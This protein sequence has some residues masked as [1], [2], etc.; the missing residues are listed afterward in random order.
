MKRAVTVI[1]I[2]WYHIKASRSIRGGLTSLSIRERKRRDRE[3]GGET[4]ICGRPES[5]FT[6]IFIWLLLQFIDTI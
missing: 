4:E 6:L 3:E 5:V 2:S 1:V